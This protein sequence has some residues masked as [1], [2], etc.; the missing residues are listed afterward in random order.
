MLNITH[1]KIGHIYYSKRMDLQF[2]EGKGLLFVDGINNEYIYTRTILFPEQKGWPII[3]GKV[4][5]I[6]DFV[7]TYREPIKIKISQ[8]L[9]D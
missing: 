3:D 2:P 8:L 5:L 9:G 1:F 4:D 6:D 7:D